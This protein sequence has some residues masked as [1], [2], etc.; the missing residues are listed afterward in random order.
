M[1]NLPTRSRKMLIWAAMAVLLAGLAATGLL[2]RQPQPAAGSALFGG[3][4]QLID[5]RGRSQSE[6][7]LKG[8]Y[9]LIYFGYTFCPDVCPTDVASL[10]AGL[11]DFE[12]ASPKRGKD[13]LPIFITVD[14][15]RDTPQALATF[16]T[17]FHPRMIG[18]T[19]TPEAARKAREAW[20]IYAARARD[21]GKGKDYYVDHQAMIFLTGPDGR[22]ISHIGNNPRPEAIVQWLDRWVKA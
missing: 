6:A 7:I 9:S 2:Q 14:P 10:T 1:K 5:Q 13:I 16:L 17:A 4:F 3:P 19:G 15:E 21:G 18:L 22:Y 12:T 20:K 11:L 8:H